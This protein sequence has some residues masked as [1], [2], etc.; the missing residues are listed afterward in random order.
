M[1]EEEGLF[2]HVITNSDL[3]SSYMSLLNVVSDLWPKNNLSSTCNASVGLFSFETQAK[4]KANLTK[5]STKI[6]QSVVMD[7]LRGEHMLQLSVDKNFAY[8]FNFVSMTPFDIKD[9]YVILKNKKDFKVSEINGNYIEQEPRAWSIWFRRKIEI[10]KPTLVTLRLHA[11]DH[12][13]KSHMHLDVINNDDASVETVF[14]TTETAPMMFQ[15]NERGYN[16]MGYSRNSGFDSLAESSWKFIAYSDDREFELQDSFSGE[17]EVL[18]DSYSANVNFL[19]C[20]YALKLSEWTQISFLAEVLGEGEDGS[21]INVNAGLTV[22]IIREKK[23]AAGEGQPDGAEEEKTAVAAAGEPKQYIDYEVIKSWDVNSLLVVPAF[24]ISESKPGA[25]DTGNY[26][27]QVLLNP[28][29]CNFDLQANGES[30]V[31]L[32]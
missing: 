8:N 18:T 2:D 6:E 1:T 31:P 4:V 28:D 30:S 25:D 19:V 7:F 24:N 32:Q 11:M 9:D 15:P 5:L 20:R 21:V 23:S 16:V 12:R 13:M 27:I 17:T 14:L 3:S 26:M 22:S 10:K 29:R